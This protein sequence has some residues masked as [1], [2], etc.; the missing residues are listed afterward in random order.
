MIEAAI[1]LQLP[2][3]FLSAGQRVPEDLQSAD[4][5]EILNQVLPL[6]LDEGADRERSRKAA[7]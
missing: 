2:I 6:W 7:A 5:A 3:S 4:D 1:A